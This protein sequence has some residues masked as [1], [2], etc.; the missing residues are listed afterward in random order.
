M[1]MAGTVCKSQALNKVPYTIFNGSNVLITVYK[2][3]KCR[4]R[5]HIIRILYILVFNVHMT[6][7][8]I[9]IQEYTRFMY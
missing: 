9:A 5:I 8:K 2:I 6:A 1:H 4:L 7:N 3:Y